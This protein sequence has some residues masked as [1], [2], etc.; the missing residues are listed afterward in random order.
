VVTFDSYR[1]AASCSVGEADLVLGLGETGLR[2]LHVP[3]EPVLFVLFHAAA[4]GK[5]GAHLEL[6]L[7]VA[8]FRSFEIPTR[9]ADRQLLCVCVCVCVC[10]RARIRAHAPAVRLLQIFLDAPAR[11][12]HARKRVLRAGVLLLGRFLVPGK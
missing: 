1:H 5:H 9:A 11:L 8:V 3:I 10:A 12:V 7:Q 2:G 6:R 4:G